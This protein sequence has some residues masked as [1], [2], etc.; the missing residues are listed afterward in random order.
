[1]VDK[2]AKAIFTAIHVHRNPALGV[3]AEL[4]ERV[5]ANPGI[6]EERSVSQRE[7]S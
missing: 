2:L 1:M 4:V 7:S 5:W 6:S 3:G